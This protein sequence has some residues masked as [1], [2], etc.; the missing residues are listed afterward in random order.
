V[1]G[2]DNKTYNNSCY[3]KQAGVGVQYTGE[4]KTV[5]APQLTVTYQ[6][7]DGVDNDKDGYIDLKDPGCTDTQD[8]DETNPAPAPT[9][10]VVYQ[11]S[12]GIDNDKDGYIDLKDPGCTDSKDNDETNV[13]PPPSTTIAPPKIISFTASPT[14]I[15]LKQSST[16]YWEVSGTDVKI[17]LDPTKETLSASGKK[18]VIP[19]S[20]IT[21][22]IIATNSAGSVKAS[23]IITVK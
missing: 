20:T 15:A 6:C 22:T 16:L 12:D 18:A 17:I 13:T 4:C 21:Y 19:T 11:C 9:T 23:V 5:T 3:A 7:N 2:A 14:A 10:T 8:N 1:C